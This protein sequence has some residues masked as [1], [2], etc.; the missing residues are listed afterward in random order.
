MNSKIKNRSIFFGFIIVLLVVFAYWYR[1]TYSMDVA[2]NQMVNVREMPERIAIATQGSTFKNT[3]VTSIINQYKD[4][5]VYI[6]VLDISDLP[7]LLVNEY[8]AIVILHTWEYG[9]PPAQ[10]SEFINVNLAAKEKFIVMAT[11]GQG[12]NKIE[13]IDALSGESILENTGDYADDI[14]E[15]IEMKF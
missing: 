12:S 8:N 7:T 14:I 10:V 5:S 13:G 15:R 3:I 4:D 11:S 2:S 6:N 9:R 1:A